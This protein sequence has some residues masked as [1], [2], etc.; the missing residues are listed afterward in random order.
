MPC[1]HLSTV[2]SVAFA[3]R[4]LRTRGCFAEEPAPASGSVFTSVLGLGVL[5]ARGLR[6]EGFP[7]ESSAR[8]LLVPHDSGA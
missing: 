4:G 5:A 1:I 7:S 2:G 3:E 8:A 6:T